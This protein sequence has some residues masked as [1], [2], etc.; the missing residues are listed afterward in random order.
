VRRHHILG[1]NVL[2]G[3][4]HP[5]LDAA[6]R[7]LGCFQIAPLGRLDQPVVILRRVFRVDRQPQ[8]HL[9]VARQ[10]DREL[11]PLIA[12]RPHLDITRVLVSG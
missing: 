12:A 4:A 10:F 11:D 3:A 6:Q 9:T 5:R 7:R 8:W 2:G 1:A